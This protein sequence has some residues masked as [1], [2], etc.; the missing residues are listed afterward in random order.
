MRWREKAHPG[1]AQKVGSVVNKA[2]GSNGKEVFLNKDHHPEIAWIYF[3]PKSAVARRVTRCQDQHTDMFG[4]KKKT[5][6]NYLFLLTRV[7][8]MNK[9]LLA[10]QM[11]NKE[12]S[13]TSL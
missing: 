3:V 8:E 11:K 6:I 10:P 4:K 12:L 5:K 9:P 1:K 7:V 13:E 2:N